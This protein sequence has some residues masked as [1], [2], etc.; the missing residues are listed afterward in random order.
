M[1]DYVSG[2]FKLSN[3]K[4]QV[5][6]SVFV[7]QNATIVGNVTISQ[8]AS[9]WFGAVLRGDMEPILIGE[10]TNIQDNTVIHVDWKLPAIIGNNVSVG[11]SVVIHGAKIGN[12]CIIGMHSTVLSGAE[13][14][15][16]CIIA[17]GAVVMQGQVVPPNSLVMGIPAKV[18]KE[19]DAETLK[20]IELNWQIY[21]DYAKEFYNSPHHKQIL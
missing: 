21:C 12:N 16:H 6:P 15:D 1:I 10:N 9:V 14:G 8:N 18:K 2:S 17:A 13:I 5:H 7:A 11:H 4:L 19:I 20:M 3:C